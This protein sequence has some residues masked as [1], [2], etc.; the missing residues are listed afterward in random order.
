MVTVTTSAKEQLSQLLKE[1]QATAAIRVY[2]AGFGWGGPS[3]GLALDESKDDDK[4]FD[5]G[6]FKVI[7]N[8]DE[9]ENIGN[10]EIDYRNSNWGSGF[11]VRSTY[12]STC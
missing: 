4:I 2:I 1:K 3:L 8:S 11:S 6:S 10:I 9:L 5:Q 7:V 12:G